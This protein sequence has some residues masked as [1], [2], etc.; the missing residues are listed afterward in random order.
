MALRVLPPPV[1]IDAITNSGRSHMHVVVLSLPEPLWPREA[2]VACAALTSCALRGIWGFGEEAVDQTQ[3]DR[4]DKKH[5]MWV[6]GDVGASP[7]TADYCS[8]L[9]ILQSCVDGRC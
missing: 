7:V 3:C 5:A 8:L 4:A 9:G 1:A 2:A 6:V